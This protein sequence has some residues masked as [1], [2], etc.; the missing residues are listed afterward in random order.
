[1]ASNDTLFFPEPKNRARASAHG[2]LCRA[3]QELLSHSPLCHPH[4]G[5]GSHHLPC[6]SWAGFPPHWESSL[7]PNPGTPC[8]RPC[9]SP[10]LL[11]LLR[12]GSLFCPCASAIQVSP[13]PRPWLFPVPASHMPSR[14]PTTSILA[15]T[16][17]RQ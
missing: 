14:L 13:Y 3:P 4:L 1:M 6:D 5:T 17:P 11:A 15:P 2:T 16:C 9:P 10:A 12:L 8:F 7:L